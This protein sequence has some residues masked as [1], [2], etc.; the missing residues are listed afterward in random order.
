[1]PGRRLFC[2]GGAAALC[3]CALVDDEHAAGR[4]AA[5]AEI[6]RLPPP[7]RR[8]ISGHEAVA[9]LRRISSRLEGPARTVCTE[10]GATVCDW[11]V[12]GSRDRQANAFATGGGRIVVHRGVI[13]AARNDEEVAFVVAHEMAHQAANHVAE[14]RQYRQVGAAAGAMALG[15]LGLAGVAAGL[16][17]SFAVRNL[18]TGAALGARIGRIAFS[19]EQ[20]READ[21]LAALILH[22]AG[23]DLGLARGFLVTMGRISS[24]TETALF[25]THPAGP[26]RLAAFDETVLRIRGI[27]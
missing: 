26:E 7:P 23:Y 4:E 3:G 24:R 11:H 14:A 10:I 20:E 9:A 8:A 17:P 27:G 22:R 6:G 13:E 5:E 21:Y 12:E 16:P 15:V 25:D 19:Q 1:M 2:L 18:E